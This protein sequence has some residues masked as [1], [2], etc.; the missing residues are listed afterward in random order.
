MSEFEIDLAACRGRQRR[1]LAEMERQRL[2]LVIVTQAEH[3]QWLAGP[4]FDFKF[5][6]IAALA[7]D[8]RLTLVAPSNSGKLAD[9]VAAADEIVPYE[10]QWLSTLRNDQRAASS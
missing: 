8:G 9:I 10:A 2:D 1:V 7:A 5:S 4:R 3:V 6:P